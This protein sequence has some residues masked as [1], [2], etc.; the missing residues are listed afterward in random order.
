M[1]RFRR[2]LMVVVAVLLSACGQ[3]GG[4]A[5]PRA[6]DGPLTCGRPAAPIAAIQGTA[7]MSPLLGRLVEVEAT[8]TANTRGLGGFFVQAP[9]TE[10]DRDEASSEA[11]FVVYAEPRPRLK[12]GLRVRVRGRVAELGTPPETTTALVEVAQVVPCGPAAPI[13]P[14][15]WPSLAN[16][17]TNWEAHEAEWLSLPDPVTV[18]STD[19]LSSAGE[20]VVSLDGRDFVPTEL[21]AP[22]SKAEERASQNLRTRLI[23]DDAQ[24]GAN[25]KALWM[26]P[27][28]LSAESPLRVDS[29]LHGIEGILEQREQAWRLQ[30]TAPIADVRQAPRP[31]TPPEIDGDLRIASFN[32]LNYFNGDGQGGGFPS[33]RGAKSLAAFKRQRAKIVAA[34]N[35][36]DADVVALMEIENDGFAA[37]SAIADLNGALNSVRAEGKDD[38]DYVRFGD[39][40]IGTDLIT[41]G[42]LYRRSRVQTLG[43]AAV[44]AAEPFQS[45]ARLPLAQSF[46]ADG[47]IFTVIANHFKSKGGCPKSNSPD[48]ASGDGQGCW[49]ATRVEMARRLFEWMQTDPTG[50]GSKAALLIG[51]FNAYG[52]EDPMRLLRDRGLIDLVE[53]YAREPAYSFQFDGASGRL[54]HALATVAF[55]ALVS[56]AAEWHINADESP[57]FEYDAAPDAATRRQRYRPDAYRSSDHDPLL[58]GL[59]LPEKSVTEPEAMA[60]Q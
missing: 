45:L 9:A 16:S 20:I 22:G 55:A 3:F 29:Q 18:I 10:Q 39:G 33:A 58:L 44:L 14:R 19:R 30:L 1:C 47:Q 6:F 56:G 15:R 51:D 54:D 13:K 40:P 48:Q 11:L 25:P 38:Y 28:T 50:C 27:Q 7:L 5:V 49:N 41:V 32:V 60:A 57:D 8:L 53:V 42:L 23:L 31:A 37:A 59:R 43:A 36:L 52:Q 2:W 46:S 12:P 26:L 34:L 21:S 4:E 17:L 24:L 35:A